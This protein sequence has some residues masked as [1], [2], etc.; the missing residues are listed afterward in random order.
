MVSATAGAVQAKVRQI[1]DSAVEKLLSWRD[2]HDA[3]YKYDN[4]TD[5]NGGQLNHY[6]FCKEGS[7]YIPVME[8]YFEEHSNISK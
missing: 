1:P 3:S 8:A 5:A 7:P 4:V 6:R 2:D